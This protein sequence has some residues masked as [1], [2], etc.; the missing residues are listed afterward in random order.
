MLGAILGSLVAHAGPH[1]VQTG[2]TNPNKLSSEYIGVL[3]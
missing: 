2:G 1:D 3:P